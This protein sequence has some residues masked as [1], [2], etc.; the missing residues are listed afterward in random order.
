MSKLKITQGEWYTNELKFR[1][2]ADHCLVCTV[3]DGKGNAFN[4][5]AQDIE[6]QQANATLIA[7]A[8]TT[9]NKCG[10]LPSELLAE[11]KRI[12]DNALRLDHENRELLQQNE[13]L[14]EA[15]EMARHYCA[16]ARTIDKSELGEKTFNHLSNLLTK[17]QTK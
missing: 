15:L 3:L 9:Y 7:D 13:E 6:T 4:S 10:L 11:N 2:E 5:L 14:K 17:Y 16:L 12:E 1:V 8:G